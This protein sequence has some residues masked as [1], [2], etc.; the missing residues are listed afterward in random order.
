MS[1]IS[2]HPPMPVA[3]SVSPSLIVVLAAIFVFAAFTVLLWSE[4]LS[5]SLG[6]RISQ[7]EIPF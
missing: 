6:E 3:S 5:Q 4:P 2:H 1:Y 7:M